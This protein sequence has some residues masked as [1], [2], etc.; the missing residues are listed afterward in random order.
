MSLLLQSNSSP[1]YPIYESNWI[2]L[3]QEPKPSKSRSFST[4]RSILPAGPYV[5]ILSDEDKDP[6]LSEPQVPSPLQSYNQYERLNLILE[7]ITIES[8]GSG[9]GARGGNFI[10]RGQQ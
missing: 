10:D 6:Q 9:S 4:V 8:Q 1:T 7:Q 3:F 2:I 5:A